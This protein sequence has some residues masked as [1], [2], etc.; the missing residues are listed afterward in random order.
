MYSSQLP[1]FATQPR[2]SY[3]SNRPRST[4]PGY[5]TTPRAPPLPR[6]PPQ[7]S[8]LT[9]WNCNQSHKLAHCPHKKNV[10]RIAENRLR[11][12]AQRYPNRHSD[13][14][15]QVLYELVEQFDED[16][17]PSEI[18]T[19]IPD[20]ASS[21]APDPLPQLPPPEADP[22]SLLP[23]NMDSERSPNPYIEQSTA[24]PQNTFSSMYTQT[25]M[26]PNLPSLSNALADFWDGVA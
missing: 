16:D 25:Q 9:C 1:K 4:Y 6:A 8:K 21:P 13:I 3:Q 23:H 26:N 2:N 10:K 7:P 17:I 20:P 12:Y 18:S 24:P 5:S 14:A 15:A 22:D 11:F 19:P